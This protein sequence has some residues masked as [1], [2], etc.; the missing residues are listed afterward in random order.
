MT[1]FLLG[2]RGGTLLGDG[3][4]PV[5]GLAVADGLSAVIRGVAIWAWKSQGSGR[6][7]ADRKKTNEKRAGRLSEDYSRL[8]IREQELMLAQLRNA[9]NSIAEGALLARSRPRRA[10]RVTRYVGTPSQW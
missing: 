5:Y 1:L 4:L 8:S 2:E 7:K 6:N 9:H 3:A 10:V